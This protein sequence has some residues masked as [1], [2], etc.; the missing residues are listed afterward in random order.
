MNRDSPKS[1]KWPTEGLHYNL[2]PA[3]PDYFRGRLSSNLLWPTWLFGVKP[4]AGF[5]SMQ[6]QFRIDPA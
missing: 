2:E 1:L 4:D 3:H 6:P 5:D